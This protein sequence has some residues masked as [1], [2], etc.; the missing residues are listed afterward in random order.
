MLEKNEDTNKTEKSTNDNASLE[1]GDYEP[2]IK[3]RK[4]DFFNKESEKIFKC[5]K[6]SALLKN[7]FQ[8]QLKSENVNN[9]EITNDR[10]GVLEKS[11]KTEPLF[12]TKFIYATIVFNSFNTSDLLLPCN[13]I[14][15]FN[16]IFEVNACLKPGYEFGLTFYLT[17]LLFALL[18]IIMVVFLCCF[19][20]EPTNIYCKLYA[21]KKLI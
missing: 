15:F 11:T 14:K 10:E 16:S 8:Y 7:A 20:Y 6:E 3:T 13:Q 18:L 1:C 5:S 17:I 4:V 19:F 21:F 2:T 12:L 9:N